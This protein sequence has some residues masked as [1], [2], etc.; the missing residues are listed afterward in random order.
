MIKLIRTTSELKECQRTLDCDSDLALVPTMGNLHAGHI[1]LVD[2]A[3]EKHLEGKSY[4]AKD[5]HVK[6]GFFHFFFKY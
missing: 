2:K 6:H 1:S 4:I 5:N 3:L